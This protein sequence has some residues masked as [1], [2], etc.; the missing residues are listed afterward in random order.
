MEQNLFIT[1]E[2]FR[3]LVDMAEQSAALSETNRGPYSPGHPVRRDD[4]CVA[5]SMAG[6]FHREWQMGKKSTRTAIQ[7]V[8]SMAAPPGCVFE[9]IKHL[10]RYHH[11]EHLYMPA[12]IPTE[13]RFRTW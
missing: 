1:R 3:T 5:A 9:N 6:Y 8:R 7:L 2:Q 10:D 12:V 4:N 11:L 13:N